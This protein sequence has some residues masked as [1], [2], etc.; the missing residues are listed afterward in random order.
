MKINTF[1]A[2][3]IA[4]SAF[5]LSVRAQSNCQDFE[6][7]I[8]GDTKGIALIMAEGLGDNSAPRQTNRNLDI[9]S[10]FQLININLQLQIQNKCPVRKTSINPMVYIG[11]ALDCNLARLKG[12]K[13]SPTCDTRNWKGLKK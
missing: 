7:A 12:E 5:S 4:A 13:D 1:I 8:D 3:F 2:A 11:E 6:T 10:K 9:N